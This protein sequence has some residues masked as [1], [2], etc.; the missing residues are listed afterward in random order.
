MRWPSRR[1]ERRADVILSLQQP[2]PVLERPLYDTLHNLA[3]GEAEGG[4]TLE[5][6]G[7]LVLD[8]VSRTAF[9]ARSQRSDAAAAQA[10]ASLHGYQAFTW[11]MVASPA[12]QFSFCGCFWCFFGWIQS[13]RSGPCLTILA[14]CQVLPCAL[15]HMRCEW[16]QHLPHQCDD[17]LRLWLGGGVLR[18]R[19]ASCCSSSAPPEFLAL[20]PKLSAGSG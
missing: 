5:G 15:R 17:E 10:W 4:G 19:G 12:L 3:A 14:P 8:R 9:V 16:P 2:C 6:T 13:S 18:R 1:L 11:R 7:S 20:S